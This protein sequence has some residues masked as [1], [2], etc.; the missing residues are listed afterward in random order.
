MAVTRLWTELD[1]LTI[2]SGTVG[3]AVLKDRR[4]MRILQFL[5]KL[6]PEFEYVCAQLLAEKELLINH[7]LSELNGLK[8]V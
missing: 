1:L 8:P 6:R 7:V 3:A 5:M 4:K 2:S